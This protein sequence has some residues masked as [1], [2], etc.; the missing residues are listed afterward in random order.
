MAHL[1][2]GK[3]PSD[4]PTTLGYHKAVH[5]LFCW[6]CSASPRVVAQVPILTPGFQ[7]EG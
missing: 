6:R 3:R 2:C 1:E 5:R 4:I 7:A